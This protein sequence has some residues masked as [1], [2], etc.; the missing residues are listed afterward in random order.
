MWEESFIAGESTDPGKPENADCL[1]HL[2]AAL[3]LW[4]SFSYPDDLP[5]K[6][7]SKKLNE[8]LNELN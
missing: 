4:I 1:Q 6:G 8:K 3:Q 2:Q 7:S 5:H